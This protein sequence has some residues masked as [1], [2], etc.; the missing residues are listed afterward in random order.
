[1]KNKKILIIEDETSLASALAALCHTEAYDA[2]LCYSG[3]QGRARLD[4]EPFDLVVLDIG[5]P[6]MNG[7]RLLELMRED[8]IETPVLVIT[9]HGNL[10]NALSAR[11]LGAADY[12]VKPFDLDVVKAKMHQLTEPAEAGVA[13]APASPVKDSTMMIGGGPAMQSV[14]TQI[15]H[16]CVSDVPV[17]ITGETGSGKTLCAG[18]I[19]ANSERSRNPFVTLH[20]SALPEQLLESELFGYE[21]NAF[22]GAATQRQGHVERAAGGVLFLDEIG[23][24]PLS[25]QV[26]LL[27]FVEEK[28]FCRLGGRC[29]ITVDLRLI[30]ASNRDLKAEVGAGRFREDLYY[31]LRVLEVNMPALNERGEDMPALCAFFLARAAPDR[32]L[33][34]SDEAMRILRNYAWPGNIR[35]LRNA[36]EHAVAVCV[37]NVIRG[38]HLPNAI[39]QSTPR[40]IE[41]SGD[42]DRGLDQWLERRLTPG[43]EYDT[44]HDELEALLLKK[45]LARYNHKTTIMAADLNMNRSTLLKKRK[46]MNLDQDQGS[47]EK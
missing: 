9:A 39:R 25:V 5:L 42:L 21:K 43:V 34:L 19:H 12:L 24:I 20:C 6:D 10:E 2:I 40:V 14:F 16:A 7:L 32:S 30:T 28:V 47:W 18:I 27:R 1:M 36:M 13:P 8:G 38:V 45:L 11:K 15:A 31:R 17:L 22:T 37:G 26:K 35:E 3:A 46:R 33:E 29:D 41:E 4:E 44:L 23:D